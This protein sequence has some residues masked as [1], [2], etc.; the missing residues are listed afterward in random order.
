[1]F[2]AGC[3]HL[4]VTDGIWKLSYPICLYKVVVEVEGI[5][6]IMPNCCPNEPEFGKPFCKDHSERLRRLSVPEDL[7]GFLKHFK[8]LTSATVVGKCLCISVLIS[9]FDVYACY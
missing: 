1:M 6:V 7:L 4:L 9:K 8:G 3:G 2:N 5:K